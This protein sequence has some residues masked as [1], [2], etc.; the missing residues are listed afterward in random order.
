MAKATQPKLPRDDAKTKGSE[1][2][3]LVDV[4]ERIRR[5]AYELWELGGRQA[6]HDQAHWLQAE[7]EIL[8]K[9]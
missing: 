6:G 9:E 1:P 3:P 4:N 7:R 5:R 2:I 8:G